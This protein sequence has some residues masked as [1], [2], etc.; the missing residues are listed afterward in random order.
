MSPARAKLIERRFCRTYR[1]VKIREQKISK[2]VLAQEEMAIRTARDEHQAIV[3]T[4]APNDMNA[5]SHTALPHTTS[6]ASPVLIFAE[7]ARMTTRT[8]RERSLGETPF[9]SVLP[10]W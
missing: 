2:S 3:L 10:A 6:N 8:S 9:Q 7:R 4:S 5:A 1:D